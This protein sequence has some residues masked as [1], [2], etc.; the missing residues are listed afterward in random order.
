MIRQLRLTTGL[1]MASFLTLHLCNHALGLVSL[2][3]MERMLEVFV[4]FWHHPVATLLLYGSFATHFLLA[5]WSL[6]CRT[7]LKMPWWEALQLLLGLSILPLLFGHVIGTRIS[8]EWMEVVPRYET[9]VGILWTIDY[10][11]LRQSSLILVVWLHLLIGLHYW[12]RLRPGYLRWL[13]LWQLLATLLPTLSLL[14]FY[15]MGYQVGE[16]DLARR[17]ALLIAEH[18]QTMALIQDLEGQLLIGYLGALV[19][20][21]IARY[22]R[23]VYQVNFGAVMV[24]HPAKGVIA[25]KRGQSLLEA[26]RSANVPHSSVCG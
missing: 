13:P 22:V 7:T 20:V 21:C 10:G 6:Y 23:R 2:P 24:E 5:L 18:P 19:L 16:I 25:A 1:I 3:M 11:V 8:I 12:Q 4:S 9:V 17:S 15:R 26:L 14:G